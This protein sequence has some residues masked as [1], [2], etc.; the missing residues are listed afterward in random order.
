MRDVFDH[1]QTVRPDGHVEPVVAVPELVDGGDHP[2]DVTEEKEPNDWGRDPG[3]PL[4]LSVTVD[5]GRPV[6]GVQLGGRG[7]SPVL[8]LLVSIAGTDN[9]GGRVPIGRVHDDEVAVFDFQKFIF[10]SPDFPHIA[11]VVS[12]M[13][14]S[15]KNC[16]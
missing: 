12:R 1:D 3:Q 14:F 13:S 8:M 5:A 6:D 10:G 16:N 15:P 2:P 7:E 4:F 9:E 11:I